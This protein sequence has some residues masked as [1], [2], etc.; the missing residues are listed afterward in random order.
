MYSLDRILETW[1]YTVSTPF[2]AR[3]VG[4]GICFFTSWRFWGSLAQDGLEFPIVS[5]TERGFLFICLIPQM[6]QTH[7]S[8]LMAACGLWCKPNDPFSIEWFLSFLEHMVIWSSHRG[9]QDRVVSEI[10][11][12]SHSP[13]QRGAGDRYLHIKICKTRD[14]YGLYWALEEWFHSLCSN[15]FH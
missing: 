2:P 12:C 8:Q 10:T 1:V 9:E 11:K 15:M 6:V 5:C 4:F 13:L 3:L 14:M 7:V